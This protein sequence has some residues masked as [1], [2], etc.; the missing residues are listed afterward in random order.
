V[1]DLEK[2]APLRGLETLFVQYIAEFLAVH[3]SA[4]RLD[5]SLSDTSARFSC[6]Q[7]S[8]ELRYQHGE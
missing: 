2:T 4:S 7:S 1:K 5:F 8:T 6:R 3:F